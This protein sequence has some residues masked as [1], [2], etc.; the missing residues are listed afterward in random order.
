MADPVIDTGEFITPEVGF[1]RAQNYVREMH[2][3][4]ADKL[5]RVAMVMVNNA[6]LTHKEMHPIVEGGMER[7]KMMTCRNVRNVLGLP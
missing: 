6:R 2:D 4:M 5:E 1:Q 3:E 7:C